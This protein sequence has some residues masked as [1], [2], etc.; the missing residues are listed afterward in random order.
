MSMRPVS[1]SEESQAAASEAGAAIYR[2]LSTPRALVAELR[3][4]LNTGVRQFALV[5][6][7]LTFA[8]PQRGGAGQEQLHEQVTER[9]LTALRSL[10][11]RSDRVFLLGRRGYFLLLGVDERGR[12]RAEERL[13][14]ALCSRVGSLRPEELHGLRSLSIG[15]CAGSTEQLANLRQLIRAAS[16]PRDRLS[17][18]FS[19]DSSIPFDSA[20]AVPV[21][22][23]ATWADESGPA[24][25]PPDLP[26][27]ARRCGL[28]YLSPLPRDV[29]DKVLRSI[30]PGLALE[31]RCFPLGRE[32]NVLTV[33]IAD[34]DNRTALERLRSATGLH[35]FPVL[36]LPHE[37]QGA[38]ERLWH[39]RFDRENPPQASGVETPEVRRVSRF[40]GF[41]P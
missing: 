12:E 28:P 29:P 15:S 38:L 16:Q 11:R 39:A 21:A 36:T 1:P 9:L 35:I 23:G 37:L 3:G 26:L 13:R 17:W 10:L 4:L 5:V 41:S 14:W 20:S 7:A 6:I 22:A 34:P 33:A 40:V 2:R 18:P 27:L 8:H 31:L 19:G 32:R 25:L 24:F 30:D